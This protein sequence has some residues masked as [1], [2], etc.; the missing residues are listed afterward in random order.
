MPTVPNVPNAASA[1][2]RA[3]TD[4]RLAM[5][6][7]DGRLVARGAT[8]ADFPDPLPDGAA[9]RPVAPAAGF[10][11]LDPGTGALVPAVTLPDPAAQA[12]D[13]RARAA[14]VQD[15]LTALPAPA[16]PAATIA[17]L[18]ARVRLLEDAVRALAA[19]R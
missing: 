10:G 9:L 7:R 11:L 4:L 12:A 13:R 1:P 2:P 3:L 5:F 18:L 15:A 8:R 19:A 17:A 16:A 14:A 6:D